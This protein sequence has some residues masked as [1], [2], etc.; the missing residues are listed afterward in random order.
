MTVSVLSLADLFERFVRLLSPS[1]W[2]RLVAMTTQD[3]VETPFWTF[4]ETIAEHRGAPRA[5]RED[6][7]GQGRPG[8]Q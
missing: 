8:A 6:L 5:R 3:L 4:A 7:E 1:D 2:L